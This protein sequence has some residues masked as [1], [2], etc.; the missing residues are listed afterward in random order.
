MPATY[1][2]VQ[3]QVRTKSPRILQHHLPEMTRW[4]SSH[5]LSWCGENVFRIVNRNVR[6]EFASLSVKDLRCLILCLWM[7]E[8]IQKSNVLIFF[9]FWGIIFL[10]DL[11]I[12]T[13]SF[14]VFLFF[15]LEQIATETRRCTTVRNCDDHA[16][17]LRW[18]RTPICI[19]VNYEWSIESQGGK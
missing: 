1:T 5:T 14:F 6:S 10:L 15:K 9:I 7:K 8:R 16:I 12:L 11:C 4:E 3:G 18:A 17:P 13:N 2:F 19:W